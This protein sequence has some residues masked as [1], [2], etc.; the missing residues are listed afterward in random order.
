MLPTA[1]HI[2][3]FRATLM[4]WY[5]SAHRPL[6]WKEHPDPYAIWLSEIILQQTRVA[7][8]LPYYERFLA[9]FPKVQALA[10]APSDEVM[11][12]WEGLG[13]YSRARNLH[14]AAKEV[15]YR[16]GGT[17]PADY[18]ALLALPGIG[19]YTAAAI[20]SFAFGLPHAVLDGNVYRV[21]ARFFG[22]DTPIDSG[23]AKPLFGGLSQNCLDASNPGRYNQA[24]MDFGATLCTPRSPNCGQCPLGDRCAARQ[25]YRVEALPVKEKKLRRRERYFHYFLL[26]EAARV[27]IRRREEG[28]IWAGLYEFPLLELEAASPGREAVFNHPLLIHWIGDATAKVK[29]VSP[30]FRQLLTHQEVHVCFWELEISGEINPGSAFM[31]VE[32]KNLSNFAWPKAIAS[33]LQKNALYLDLF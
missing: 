32:R 22:I 5:D 24:I 19:P 30:A 13:Y 10:D 14:A 33:Y 26:N 25:Q 12:L 31:Q 17:F 6:P 16:Y 21:L 20:A 1:T 18:N 23:A 2:D 7:Q 28:D 27:W 11:K 3:F 15:A 8:G 4:R 29:G 9:R